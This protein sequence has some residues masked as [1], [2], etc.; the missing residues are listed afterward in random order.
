MEFILISGRIG[1]IVLFELSILKSISFMLIP[2]FTEA[3]YL[4]LY[5]SFSGLSSLYFSA[6]PLYTNS[7]VDRSLIFTAFQAGKM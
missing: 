6:I 2:T 1:V 3:S 5:F 4:M 7:A